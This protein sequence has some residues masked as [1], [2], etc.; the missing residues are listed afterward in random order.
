MIVRVRVVV[1]GGGIAGLAAAL[2]LRQRL[3][4]A[5]DIVVIE[6]LDVLGGKLRT[7]RLAGLTAERGADAF[8]AREP[9]GT[10][11]SAAVALARR[12]GLGDALVHPA[13]VPAGLLLDGALRPLPGGTLLGVPADPA[14][15][16]SVA[17]VDIERDR[18]QGRPLLTPGADVAVGALVRQRLGDQVV[19]RLLDPLLGGVYA[20][21]AD[22]L[23]LAA[24][25]P[26]LAAACTSEHTL[27]GAVRAAQA[28]AP[29]PPGSPVFAGILGGLGRLVSAVATASGAT[30]RL[31]LPVRGLAAEGTGWVLTVGSTRN[32]QLVAAD[33]VVLALPARPA[34]RLL[35]GVAGLAEPATAVGALDYASVALVTLALPRVALPPWS[36]L[37][38]PAGERLTIKAA[39]FLTT[40]WPRLAQRTPLAYPDTGPDP[41]LVRASVGRYGEPQPLRLADPALVRQVH[42]ELGRALG[43]ELPAPLASHV[44]R[45]GGALP[46]YAPGHLD[47]V[48]AARAALPANLGLAGAGYDGVGIPA[49]IRS[50]ETAADRVAA[51]LEQSTV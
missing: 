36:G 1:V 28:A 33:A 6:Q 46:Q 2:R 18:D 25:M 42:A 43:A 8:L 29:R 35:A 31:G 40:K 22:A 44:Q 4:K 24:T 19:D 12:V 21:R 39:T 30:L 3:G 7:G 20:G 16:A 26:G 38:V 23:S 34:A 14:Q 11:E 9:G 27:T 41:V 32:P 51:V 10:G 48:A 15:V 45:W 5:A 37:L 50:G 17:T 13:P 49:C 47:R